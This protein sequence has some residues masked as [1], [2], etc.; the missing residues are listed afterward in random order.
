MILPKYSNIFVKMG[1]TFSE[2]FIIKNVDTTALDLT[3]YT[4]EASFSNSILPQTSVNA[5][6]VITINLT[7]AI[8]NPL[9]GIITLSATSTET[10][11]YKFGRYFYQ[12]NLIDSSL[13]KFRV[14]EGILTVDP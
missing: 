5:S 8:S 9:Q 6:S 11:A 1:S 12:V 4:I 14:F 7:S 10:A 3:P 13:N 2:N